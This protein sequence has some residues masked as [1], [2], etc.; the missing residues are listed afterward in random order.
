MFVTDFLVANFADLMEVQVHG[1]DGGGARQ[2]QRGR[3]GLARHT[4][5][6]YHVLLSQ[7]LA[8]AGE[9]KSVRGE[10]IPV[11]EKCPEL[12]QAAGHPDGR[13]GQFKA[14]SGYPECKFKQSLTKPEVTLLEEK[15]PTCGAQLVRRRGRYGLFVA[16][17]NYPECKYIQKKVSEKVETG[18]ACPLGCGGML[19]K[20]TTRR[21]KVFYGCGHFPKC[22]FASWDEPLEP[23]LP[24]VRQA[25]ALPEETEGRDHPALL[26]RRKVRLQGNRG[27]GR[28]GR[29]AGKAAGHR[30]G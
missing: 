9:A 8:K 3:G 6:R 25:G 18:I 11:D 21:G 12:R 29:G 30:Q 16:C 5:R 7:D 26:S 19:L 20:R 2:D 24:E 27:R 10:G 15:C 4:L 22:R 23:C 1:P 28:R 14:C 17:S 13:F